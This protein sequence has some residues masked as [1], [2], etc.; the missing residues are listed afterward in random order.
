MR[1]QLVEGL[2]AV[3]NGAVQDKEAKYLFLVLDLLNTAAVR[4]V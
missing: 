4:T 2:H 1:A 3:T